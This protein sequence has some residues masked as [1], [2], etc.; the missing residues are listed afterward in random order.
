MPPSPSTARTT[1]LPPIFFP[2]RSRELER[3]GGSVVCGG[4]GRDVGG[5]RSEGRGGGDDG[6]GDAAGK[7]SLECLR[8]SIALPV[9]G[10]TTWSTS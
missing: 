5:G 1:Y 4:G 7:L 9:D 3:P 8:R 6:Y 10:H 2:V